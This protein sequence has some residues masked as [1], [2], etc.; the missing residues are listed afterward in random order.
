[1]TEAGEIEAP[2]YERALGGLGLGT[3]VVA[4]TTTTTTTT[5][6][7]ANVQ[8]RIGGDKAAVRALPVT[9]GGLGEDVIDFS[10]LDAAPIR[11]EPGSASATAVKALA[12]E[13]EEAEEEYFDPN[14]NPRWCPPG[15]VKRLRNLQSPLIRLH[16]EIVDFSRYLE[17]TEEEATSRAAA[18]EHVRA[19]VNGIWPDARFEVHGS[20]ATGMY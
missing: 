12:V 14:E 8:S 20:F 7:D 6:E 18:V 17:P 10:Y 11:N 2:R 16:T 5:D 9:R 19:V 3:A 4:A 1:M 13:E 15:T